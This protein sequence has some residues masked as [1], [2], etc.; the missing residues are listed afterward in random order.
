M[1][2][3]KLKAHTSEREARAILKVTAGPSSAENR[4]RRKMS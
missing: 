1:K 4:P 3:T 2:V